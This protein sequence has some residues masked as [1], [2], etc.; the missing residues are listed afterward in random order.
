M[1]DATTPVAAVLEAF[2]RAWSDRSV[3][4]LTGLWDCEDP[5]CS[6]LAASL[7]KR[8]VGT[9]AIV[10]WFG[11]VVTRYSAVSMRPKTVYPRR[12]N[13]NLGVAFAEVDWSLGL[14]SQRAVGGSI[15]I[16][17]VARESGQGWRLCH[18]AEAPLAPIVELRGF[19]QKVAV[20]GHEGMS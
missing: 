6:Y 16:S 13:A 14:E 20:D 12:L 2:W 4:G 8:L 9:E 1:T 7:P 11:S 5:S 15:R 17:A 18:Y 19:Y 10:G 3:D